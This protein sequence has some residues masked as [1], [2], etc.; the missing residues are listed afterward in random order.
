[1][2]VDAVFKR[3]ELEQGVDVEGL[4]LGSP[5]LSTFTVQGRVGR[6]PAFFAGSSLSTPNS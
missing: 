1:M 5:G 2:A 4:R 6:P 3:A